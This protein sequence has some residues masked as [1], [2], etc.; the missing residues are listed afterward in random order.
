MVVRKPILERRIHDDSTVPSLTVLCA[1]YE[2]GRWRQYEMAR[3]LLRRHLI[4]FAYSWSESQLVD[5]DSAADDL[6][7]AATLVYTTEKY[8]RR[9]EFGELLLHAVVKDLFRGQP[10]ISKI[11]FK[12]ATNETVKGF[13]SVHVVEA[14]EEIEL[15]LGEVKFYTDVNKAIRDVLV[16]LVEHFDASY[17]RREFLV[18]YNKID[19]QWPNSSRLRALLDQNTSLDQL[20][21]S[22][23]VPV[24]LTYESQAIAD[25]T[26][27]DEAYTSALEEEARKAWD[28]WL[29]KTTPPVLGVELKLRLILVPLENKKDFVDSLHERLIRWQDH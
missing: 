25:H 12:T 26:K 4:S 13:D 9:G 10:A 24:L 11:Y 3:D 14:G 22:I 17:L 18:I 23:T 27:L 28:Y 15:W 7:N 29:R 19:S 2:L 1:G 16:E 6:A 8:G 20:I 21:D 5:A